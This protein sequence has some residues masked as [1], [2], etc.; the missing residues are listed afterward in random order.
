MGW[1]VERVV[2]HIKDGGQ[3]ALAADGKGVFYGKNALVVFKR[4]A[5][6]YLRGQGKDVVCQPVEG[7]CPVAVAAAQMQYDAGTAVCPQRIKKPSVKGQ[8]VNG[9]VYHI[10]PG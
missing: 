7:R 9:A 5:I 2:E 3:T 8:V 1:R 4:N 6:P 10:L